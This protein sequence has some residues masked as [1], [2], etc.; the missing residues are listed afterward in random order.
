MIDICMDDS[1]NG[2]GIQPVHGKSPFSASWYKTQ[3]QGKTGMLKAA[4][5]NLRTYFSRLNPPKDSV[6]WT[7]FKSF[8]D[9][10]KPHRYTKLPDGKDSFTSCNCRATEE[11]GARSALAYMVDRHLNPGIIHFLAQNDVSIDEGE[12]ALSELIQWIFRSRIRFTHKPDAERRISLYIPSERMRNL[13]LTWLGRPIPVRLSSG[14]LPSH[15]LGVLPDPTGVPVEKR[16]EICI[17]LKPV[18]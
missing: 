6:M 4:R 18:P 12:Y 5:N 3:K 14:Q 11:F 1:L 15:N 7:T 9:D 17:D 16:S 8:K 13:L 2:I 10:L